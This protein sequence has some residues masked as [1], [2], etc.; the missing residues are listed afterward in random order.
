MYYKE[1]KIAEIAE[2]V[3]LRIQSGV[4]DGG[5]LT[6][7]VRQIFLEFQKKVT[8]AVKEM[9][10]DGTDATEQVPLQW[11]FPGALLY[12]ITVITTIGKLRRQWS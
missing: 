10:W 4:N 5:N 11:S 3:E 9:G 8:D 6:E 2:L 7:R 12:A 1:E